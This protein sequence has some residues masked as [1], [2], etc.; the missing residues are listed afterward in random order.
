M[1]IKLPQVARVK[2]APLKTMNVSLVNK[3]DSS[4][5]GPIRAFLHNLAAWLALFC[6]GR[7][8]WEGR[9]GEGQQ[10]GAMEMALGRSWLHSV[11][12]CVLGLRVL[13]RVSSG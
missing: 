5:R 9:K 10:D 4:I 6:W 2:C 12:D 1:R 8:K 3:V 13:E 7:G 11:P